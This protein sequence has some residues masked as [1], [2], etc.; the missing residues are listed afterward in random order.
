ME[1]EKHVV[2]L[3]DGCD[4]ALLP[5][6]IGHSWGSAASHGGTGW[7]IPEGQASSSSDTEGQR[8]GRVQFKFRAALKLESP[9]GTPDVDSDAHQPDEMIQSLKNGA[10]RLSVSTATKAASSSGT[11]HES[12]VSTS[13]ECRSSDSEFRSLP[14]L[15]AVSSDEES[16]PQEEQQQ[17]DQDWSSAWATHAQGACKACRFFHLKRGGC[18]DGDACR[19]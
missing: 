15:P 11:L 5:V 4:G 12:R 10:S 2:F 6:S 16:S 17:K 19:Y 7:E 9:S 8:R 18:R 14:C 13:S 1:Q 3:G